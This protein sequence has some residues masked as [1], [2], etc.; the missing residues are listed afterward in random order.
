MFNVTEYRYL[1]YKIQALQLNDE[2][3]IR[4]LHEVDGV[5][6]LLDDGFIRYPLQK[7]I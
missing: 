3:F 5:N 6:V 7:E 2:I 1:K 4:V